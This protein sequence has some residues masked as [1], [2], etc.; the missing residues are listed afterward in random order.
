MNVRLR[1][2]RLEDRDALIELQRRASLANPEDR[3]AILAHPDAI[4]IPPGQFEAG[5][6]LVAE[7]DGAAVGFAA[8]F[9]RPDRQAELDGLFVEPTHWKA[10]IGRTLVRAAEERAREHG[11]DSLHVIGHPNAN[12]FYSHV[13]F[14]ALG[15]IPT[16]F[17]PGRRFVRHLTEG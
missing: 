17:G 15:E 9:I 3:E 8:L 12:G 6:V 10:G 5:N 7:L 2:A 16:R 1:T 4:D 13:G 11:A 14:A